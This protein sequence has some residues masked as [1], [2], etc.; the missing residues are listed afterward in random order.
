MT[1]ASN[2][3]SGGGLSSGQLCEFDIVSARHDCRDR[4][5]AYCRRDP[6]VQ[7]LFISVFGAAIPNGVVSLLCCSNAVRD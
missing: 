4:F 3:K 6:K 7:L 5:D 2:R 1:Q